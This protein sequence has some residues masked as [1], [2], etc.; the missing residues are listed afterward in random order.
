MDLEIHQLELRYEPLRHRSP[1][2][3]RRLLASIAEGGQQVPIVVVRDASQYVV[4]DGYKR[5]RALRSLRQDTVAATEWALGEVDALVLE[6]LMRGGE[7]DNALGQGW[8]LKELSTRFGLG[9]PE[10]SRRFDRTTSWVSRRIALVT[11]LPASVHEHVR[12]GALGAH[13]AMKYLVPLARANAE[14]CAKLADAVAPCRPSTRQMSE[15]YATY[16]GGNARTRELCVRDPLLVLRAREEAA[17]ERSEEK[18]AVES[19]LDDMRII[20]AVA[21]RASGRLGRGV[22]DGAVAGERERVRLATAE[23]HTE[24]ESLR[25]RCHKEVGDAG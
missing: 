12:A 23:V 8:L 1:V 14:D 19:L 24:V 3:E 11:A 5:V 20:V 17:R 4:V 13:A 25:R 16:I 2:R 7:A 15:L 18:T 6:H 22:M 10:L 21:R 9:Y